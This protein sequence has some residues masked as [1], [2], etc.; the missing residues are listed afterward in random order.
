MTNYERIQGVY[1]RLDA[2]N[3]RL[4]NKMIEIHIR[5]EC[6][7]SNTSNP[8]M[9]KG[10]EDLITQIIGSESVG[11]TLYISEGYAQRILDFKVLIADMAKIRS[12]M[13][14]RLPHIKV[15]L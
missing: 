8:Y 6:D 10:V 2:A 3:I 5:Y 4:G 14:N 9:D 1:D 15:E 7:S 12:E 13:R 11:Q